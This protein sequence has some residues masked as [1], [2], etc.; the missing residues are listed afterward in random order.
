MG[1]LAAQQTLRSSQIN[2]SV[3]LSDC[4]PILRYPESPKPLKEYTLNYIGI[5]NI[6]GIGL[7]G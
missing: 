5:L 2:Q 4:L 1:A 6:R 7:F 3:W